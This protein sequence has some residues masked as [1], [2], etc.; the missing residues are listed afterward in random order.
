M[1]AALLGGT[2]AGKLELRGKPRRPLSGG[3]Q[4]M[5]ELWPVCG[6]HPKRYSVEELTTVTRAV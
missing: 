5:P 4:P 1:S 2:S 3:P 6:P